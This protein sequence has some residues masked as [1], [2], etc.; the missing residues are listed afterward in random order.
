MIDIFRTLNPDTKA[1]SHT[2]T[3]YNTILK[4][5]EQSKGRLDHALCSPEDLDMI[6]AIAYTASPI[7]NG[8]DH[9]SLIL[10]LDLDLVSQIKTE[11]PP[12]TPKFSFRTTNYFSKEDWAT[13]T[14]ESIKRALPLEALTNKLMN[15][16]NG[17][18]EHQDTTTNFLTE[19]L[20][21]IFTLISETVGDATPEHLKRSFTLTGH[22]WWQKAF[23][24]QATRARNLKLA[25]DTLALNGTDK[26]HLH[27]LPHD[28]RNLIRLEHPHLL[29]PTGS[30]EVDELIYL[31][32]KQR[33]LIL[34]TI[35]AGNR[36][37]TQMEI[38]RHSDAI[39]RSG[40]ATHMS[41]FI[42]N[43]ATRKFRTGIN[44]CNTWIKNL[45]G[46]HSLS[47]LKAHIDSDVDNFF[48]DIFT[49]KAPGEEIPTREEL[50]RKDFHRMINCA[51]W[52]LETLKSQQI[53]T[54][55]DTPNNLDLDEFK[56]TIK[57]M[58][59]RLVLR[60]SHMRTIMR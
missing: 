46:K 11:P 60:L 54:N 12:N 42:A 25:I 33:R 29:N 2:H 27:L 51:P 58:G 43:R 23:N 31:L 18:V 8:A 28:T 16:L 45:S 5:H 56:R 22:P 34:Q 36:K 48:K 35:K 4:V 24:A 7:I 57:R 9:C 21:E 49:E 17:P 50:Q 59:N 30:L 13:F 53:P 15:H 41:R 44:I 3:A 1:F 26:P 37:R 52:I 47:T 39:H 38:Q 10:E 40:V 55:N 32:G 19:S 6:Q 20:D 14:L